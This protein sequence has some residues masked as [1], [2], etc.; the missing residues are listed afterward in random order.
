MRFSD[1]AMLR[2]L[3]PVEL[4]EL[5]TDAVGGALLDAAYI[6]DHLAVGDVDEVRARATVVAPEV[7][8]ARE[9]ALVVREPATAREWQWSGQLADRVETQLQ[10]I[11]DVTV[12]AAARGVVTSVTEVVTEDLGDMRPALAA[13]AD[14][15]AALAVVA[16]RMPE[17][18]ATA[19]AE[20]L[21]RRG[22]T[23]LESLRAT[24]ASPRE[25]SRLLLTL[26]SDARTPASPRAFRM[27][28]LARAVDDLAVGLSDAV[29]SIAAARR[30]IA[31]LVDPPAE[32]RGASLRV[33]FPA[34][35]LFPRPGLDDADLPFV[36]GQNPTTDATRRTSRLAELTTRLRS[37]GIVPVPV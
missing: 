22:V 33:D 13:A 19:L 26:V 21:R 7:A 34:V 17:S 12:T 20:V 15:D 16:A 27:N 30:G 32:P 4:D 14:W 23:D 37:A 2:L 6:F 31:H 1:R 24:F 3:D 25:P 18:D 5:L 11:L 35:L 9:L 29:T 10:A 28:V 36:S 8:A